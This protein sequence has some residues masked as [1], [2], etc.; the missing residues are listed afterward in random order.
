[1]LTRVL[2]VLFQC[3]SSQAWDDDE[4]VE[5]DS[6]EEEEAEV[7]PFKVCF[8]DDAFSLAPFQLQKSFVFRGHCGL[9]LRNLKFAYALLTRRL[10]PAYA[11]FHRTYEWIYALNFGFG[12]IMVRKQSISTSDQAVVVCNLALKSHGCLKHCG[13]VVRSLH[14]YL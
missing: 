12:W 9:L 10:R 13:V 7:V 2:V 8:G 3:A 4:E 6:D 11:F 14:A 1:M 5:V